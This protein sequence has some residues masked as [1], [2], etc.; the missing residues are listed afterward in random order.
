MAE[1]QKVYA[2][3]LDTAQEGQYLTGEQLQELSRRGQEEG[4][5]IARRTASTEENDTP[6]EVAK[7]DKARTRKYQYP[8][9][10]LSTAP[11]RITFAVFKIEPAFPLDEV[12]PNE[13]NRQEEQE[14]VAED[15]EY[16]SLLTDI[17]QAASAVGGFLQTYKNENGGTRLGS[18]TLPLQKSLTFADGVTY[19][20]AELGLIGALPDVGEISADNGRL[21]GAAKALGSQLA[22]KAA[23]LTLGATF[24]AVAAK[25]PGFLVGAVAADGL[26]DQAAAAA[27]SA[28][29][30]TLAPNQRTQFD[31]VNLRTFSFTFKMIARNRPE[32]KE[33]KNIVQ[34]FREELYPE[35]IKITDDGLPFAYEFP[36]VFEIRIENKNKQEPAPRIQRCY[37]ES[38]QTVYNATASGMYDGE[39]FVEVDIALSFKEITALDKS[40]VRDQG[41]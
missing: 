37:L 27:K 30:V 31:R 20:E 32:Q 13:E 35:A 1:E 26:G 5:E 25:G 29:R 41:F 17:K 39:E 34:F 2:T 40:K 11:A 16:T 3:S 22:A 21:G 10:G 7:I 23:G 38:V 28:S 14:A 18:V 36:N 33:I 24:G 6:N 19:N 15:E 4:V 12:P 9:S 8:L